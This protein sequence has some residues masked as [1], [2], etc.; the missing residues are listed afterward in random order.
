MGGAILAIARL[1][2]KTMKEWAGGTA[3]NFLD[4][5]VGKALLSRTHVPCFPTRRFV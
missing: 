5:W 3:K 1:R 4:C 2:A